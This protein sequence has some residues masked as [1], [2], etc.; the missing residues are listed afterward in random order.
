MGRLLGLMFGLTFGII[1]FFTRVGQTNVGDGLLAH[2]SAWFMI[3]VYHLTSIINK[4]AVRG[5]SAFLALWAFVAFALCLLSTTALDDD[6]G[7]KFNEEME[8]FIRK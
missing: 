8:E 4:S 1:N 5:Y 2:M 7:F 6:L 3:F